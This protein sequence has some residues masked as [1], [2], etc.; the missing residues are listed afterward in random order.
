[1]PA[2][3]AINLLPQEELKRNWGSRALDWA[4]TFGRYVV[5]LTELVVIVA[6]LARF[7]YDRR[8]DDLYE[9]IK[10]KQLFIEANA[11]FETKFRGVQ[12]RLLTAKQ[13]MS[14]QLG[15]VSVFETFSSIVPSDVKFVN[16]SFIEDSFR[17]TG[18]ASS[19]TGLAR[20]VNGL[21]AAPNLSNVAISSIVTSADQPG[22]EFTV[23]GNYKKQ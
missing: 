14:S 23:T 22:L 11:D 17:L 7:G 18:I 13:A 1:M 20:L 12:A 19:E 6:F 5:I 9:T 8:L 3:P 16:F 2:S 4:L 15:A 21:L 10:Q